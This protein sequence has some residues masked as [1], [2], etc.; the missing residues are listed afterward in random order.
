MNRVPAS[1]HL[2]DY[3]ASIPALHNKTVKIYIYAE[4][5]SLLLLISEKKHTIIS[6]YFNRHK[7]LTIIWATICIFKSI[8]WQDGF[9][10]FPFISKKKAKGSQS[11]IISKIDYSRRKGSSEKRNQSSRTSYRDSTTKMKNK[12]MFNGE[13]SSSAAQASS[14]ARK[15]PHKAPKIEEN[16]KQKKLMGE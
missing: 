4:L 3:R 14:A 12:K 1:T 9:A 10:L 8:W 5:A 2:T 6:S 15:F 16:W 7:R 11:L 13:K